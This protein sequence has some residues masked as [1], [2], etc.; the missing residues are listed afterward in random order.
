MTLL[1]LSGTRE[2]RDIAKSLHSKGAPLIASLAGAT[3]SPRDQDVPT[4]IGGFG[5]ADGFEAFL[6][7]HKINAVLDATHPFASEISARSAQICARLTIPYCIYAR[8]AW[9]PTP[10]DKWT[11]LT[12]EEDASDH[13][14]KGS[15]VFLATG[16]KTL[17]RFGNLASC[18]LICRQIDPPTGPFPFPNGEFL[19]GRP[20]FSIADEVALF[21]SLEV[22]WLIVKNAGGTSSF[23]KLDAARALGLKVGMIKRPALPAAFSVSSIDQ[24]IAWGASHG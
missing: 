17:E 5:G 12:Q 18:R 10:Q 15:T 8:P 3:R 21:K 4:R 9:T 19:I 1:V 7:E 16:R 20:P 6:K 22:D 11:V 14:A 24:A 2:G 13:I 23:S